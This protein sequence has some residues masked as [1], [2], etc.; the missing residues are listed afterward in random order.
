M[1]KLKEYPKL[2]LK[3]LMLLARGDFKTLLNNIKEGFYYSFDKLLPHNSFIRYQLWKINVKKEYRAERNQ[4]KF[5]VIYFYDEFFDQKLFKKLFE[6]LKKQKYS[7]YRLFRS[8]EILR[9]PDILRK[10]SFTHLC[11]VEQGDSI[12][13]NALLA[14]N[15]ALSM[16]SPPDVIYTDEDRKNRLGIRY[17][18]YFKPEY[19]PFLIL[20]HNYMNALLCIKI[21]NSLIVELNNTE[22]IN[23]EWMYRFVLNKLSNNAE[24]K[25]IPDVLYHR[26]DD[27]SKKLENNSTRE[28]IQ[29]ELNK[30][31]INADFIEYGQT[32]VNKFKIKHSD[33]PKVSI[34]IPFKDK[35]SLLKACVD[36]IEKKTSYK[37]Y[38]IMLVNNRSSENETY[39]YLSSTKYSVINADID[40]NFSTLNNIAAQSA[41][42]E[43]LILLNNDTEVISPDWV[44]NMLALA[45]L[46]ETGAVG[47]KLLYGDGRIQHAGMI[48]ISDGGGHINRLMN[49]DKG[50][51]MEYNGLIREYRAVTGACLMVSREKYHEAGG[52]NENFAVEFNDVDFC[53]KLNDLG[54]YNVYS[55]HSVL[56]HLESISRK[57]S[58][59]ASRKD[60][61]RYK[62]DKWSKVLEDDPNYNPNFVKKGA[63][64][65]IRIY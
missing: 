59:K 4:A 56:Y 31:G 44:E 55:P 9:E 23:Q 28:I 41:D 63:N 38:E 47:A 18:A 12:S 27:N 64:F 57:K 53:L 19:L 10:E 40:F 52:L 14:L 36:S 34:I 48:V 60:E 21:S 42:G 33:N 1:A 7:D 37:N 49:S 6:G 17:G 54:Y 8:D 20:S 65:A 46:K 26:S 32:G 5:A 15:C 35:I 22:K 16:E 11:F 3:S 45:Q 58:F 51:Y 43:Y 24:I 61:H 2:F 30:R 29:E 50:G 39:E 62:L 13:N 25:R